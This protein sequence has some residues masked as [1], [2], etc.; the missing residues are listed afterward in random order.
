MCVSNV[1]KVEVALW[2]GLVCTMPFSH[3]KYQ[4]ANQ[5]IQE[6]QAS[7]EERTDQ[8]QKIKV[9]ASCQS[10]SFLY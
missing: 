10:V 5:K 8:E 2:T 1:G 3:R 9:S 6:L 7:Q 4:E